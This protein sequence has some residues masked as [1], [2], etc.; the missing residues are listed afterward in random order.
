MT[1]KLKL[2]YPLV[3][4]STKQQ[5]VALLIGVLLKMLLRIIRNL[6]ELEETGNLLNAEFI[7]L[8]KRG[9]RLRFC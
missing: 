6:E 5:S 3:W 4:E 1:G 7:T 2:Q 8:G 9:I